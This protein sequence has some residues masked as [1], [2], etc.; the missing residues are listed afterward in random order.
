MKKFFSTFVFVLNAFLIE[1]QELITYPAPQGVLY[2]QHNDDYT[3]KVRK[4]GGEWQDLFEYI[5]RV[6]MDKVQDASMVYFDFSGKVEVY[7]R[8][9]NGTLQS[10][11]VRPLSKGIQPVVSGN[12]I[13][14]VLD[15]PSKLSVE[16]NGDKLH[17]LHL[18]AS[19]IEKDRPDPKD[20]NVMYF[21]PGVHAPKDSPGDVYRVP[22]GKTVYIA[23]GAVVRAKF[24][25]DRV[26]NVRIIGRGIL[27][28]PQ[29]GVEVTHS[30]NV[31]IDGIIVVNPKHYTVY[32][33]ASQNLT[34]RNLKSFSANGWS[35]GIDLMS[36]SDVVIDDV[37]M[38]NS[39]DCIAIYAHRW[40]FYG[41]AR[42]YS[43]TNSTLWADIA[44][45]TNIGLHG[46]TNTE[47][48]TIENITFKNIDILEQDE[49]DPD[50]EGCMAISGG[51]LN[52]I[53]NIRYENIRVDDFEEG[54]LVNIRVLY[55]KKYNTGPGRN[56]SNIYF[57]NITYTG[58]NSAGSFI[59]GLDA[60]HSVKGLTFENLYINGK[61]ILNHK[62][63]NIKIGD[64]AEGI[65]FK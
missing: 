43:I 4:P 9:N 18:F 19:E 44:H 26:E 52:L 8:K 59:G 14:F 31:L 40:D 11:R 61:K 42:N 37:F 50:Y 62:D 2:T 58:N 25:C 24:V 53:R 47:G 64:F 10:V 17:N 46:N 57:K 38:R 34:I 54:Q 65:Q 41:N 36:C 35:D 48:D 3:V 51:D 39:D 33:G 63:A 20:P 30:K 21:G 5:V 60:A 7:V 13:T 45:P 55:N 28:Q 12:V 56:I 32:G 1:A 49:D 22:S 29:R 27:D 23:G 6:D 16:F 15:K